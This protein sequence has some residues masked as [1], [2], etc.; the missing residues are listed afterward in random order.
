MGGRFR[1]ACALVSEVCHDHAE[2]I[3]YMC[4]MPVA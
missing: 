4:E 2:M 1:V 3:V